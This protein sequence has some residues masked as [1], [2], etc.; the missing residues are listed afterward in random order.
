MQTQT[1]PKQAGGGKRTA[2]AAGLESFNLVLQEEKERELRQRP[3]FP[4]KVSVTLTDPPLHPRSTRNTI[5]FPC[6][7]HLRLKS[8]GESSATFCFCSA[9]GPVG[10]GALERFLRPRS[11]LALEKAGR[12]PRPP[13]KQRF[14]HL[15]CLR[16]ALPRPSEALLW[17]HCKA[18]FS[19]ERTTGMAQLVLIASRSGETGTCVCLCVP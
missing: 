19:V 16:E 17:R 7:T 10:L 14:L 12:P 8:F 15:D 5:R 9:R 2:G 3:L 18:G 11:K 1:L 13:L 4:N 6:R